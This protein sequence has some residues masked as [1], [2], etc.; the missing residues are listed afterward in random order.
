M[1]VRFTVTKTKDIGSDDDDH[2]G[3]KS[4]NAAVGSS[5]DEKKTGGDH[6]EEEDDKFDD[7]HHSSSPRTPGNVTITVDD[8]LAKEDEPLHTGE[9]NNDLYA[10]EFHKRPRVADILTNLANYQAGIQAS[11]VQ[12]EKADKKPKQKKLGTLLGVYLPCIQNIFGVILFIRLTWVVGMAGVMESFFIV[13]ICC[14]TTMLTAISMSAI[15]TNG[16][17]PAG[18]SYFMISRALGPEF[19]GAVGILFYLGTSFAAAMYIIGAIEILLTYIAPVISI[20]GDVTVEANAFNNYRVYGTCLLIV[21]ALCVFL[22]VRFVSMV[23]AMSLFCV[24]LSILAIYVGIFVSS[25]ARSVKICLLGDRVLSHRILEMNGTWFCNSSSVGPIYKSFCPESPN[26]TVCDPFFL[27]NQNNLREVPGIPGLTGGVFQ[28]NAYNKYTK[29]DNIIGTDAHGK[30][31][32][33]FIIS[34][35]TTSF[36]VLLAIFFPSCTGIMA[37]SNR[38]GDLQDAQKSIPVGTIAAIATTSFV[39]LSSVLFFGATI[40]GQLLQDKFGESIGGSL[41]VAN[42]AWP[43]HWVILIGSLLSTI[44]AGL[45]SLTGAPRLL[46]AISKDGVIPFLKVFSVTTKKGEPVRALLMTAC[47]TE[48][49]ILIASL[50]YVAPIITMF[51]LMCYGFVNLACALQTL[52]K[53]PNWRPRFRFYHWTLSLLGLL[54][55]IALMF[56]SSWYY[57]LVALVI[58]FAIYKYIEY[59]GAEQEWGD[60]IRGLAMSAAR[61]ALL[62][63]EEGPPHTKNWRPQVM[64]LIKPTDFLQVKT[65][66]MLSFS[67]Q[68][69][70]GKG[71]MVVGSVIEGD[72]AHRVDDLEV[73]KQTL[74]SV[75]KDEK[76]KGFA[77]VLVAKNTADG[78]SHLCQIEGLGGM[79]PNTVM[80]GWPTQW[81]QNHHTTT[82]RT[83]VDTIRVVNKMAN[84]LVVLKGVDNFPSNY[85]KISSGTIDVWW[86][87]HDGGML[88]LLPFLLRQHKVWKNCKT[89]IFTVAQMEDNSVQ[90]E[91][92]LRTFMY[93]LRMDA[94]VEVVEMTDSDISAYTVERTL[95]MQQRTQMLKQMQLRKHAAKVDAQNIVERAHTPGTSGVKIAMDN[96]MIPATEKDEVIE[97]TETEKNNTNMKPEEMNLYTFSPGAAKSSPKPRVESLFKSDKLSVELDQRNVKRMHTAV[98]L[99]KVITEKSQ[100]AQLVIM[101]LPGAPKDKS[102]D[103]NY[104]SFLEALT[105]GLDKV[106]MIRGGGREVVTIYS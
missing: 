90:M 62:R 30:R 24:I 14:C 102:G 29:R 43:S 49:G 99:N 97:M 1:S 20:F 13:L 45:Q 56:I 2:E 59:K 6:D 31:G 47:I 53:T 74:K 8:A 27:E 37:G 96:N 44:G 39:Y 28:E 92:D 83:F 18:G 35:I 80:L 73:F 89:R 106:V 16:V 46:Q 23:A 41:V 42:L 26:G 52:L 81:G 38:S 82:W 84:A 7:I 101:N 85:D 11:E 67:T 72:L 77:D 50:D 71:L 58:A 100:D 87:V 21:L 32:G 65:Q 55:C 51:F 9:E 104:M 98:R 60:G 12:I 3:N 4:A 15:A 48:L 33:A 17:V 64:V 91:K 86:I 25:P 78:I 88:M 79:R 95:M 103:E 10:D 36:M 5:D 68:L 93:H 70:A 61:Y 94:E 76:V 66:R 75:M 63:L 22:G 19:G 69:K 40:E 105:D 34:D 57:A 54:L